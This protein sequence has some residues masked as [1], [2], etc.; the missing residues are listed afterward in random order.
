MNTL[1]RNGGTMG[2]LSAVVF[3]VLFL[4]FITSGLDFQTMNDPSKALPAFSQSPGRWVATGLV[5][6]VGSAVEI[7]FTA[8]LFIKLRER[9]PTRA[10]TVLLLAVVGSTGFALSSLLQWLGGLQ[11][12]ARL[13][14][15]QVAAS[16][17]YV[18]LASV[19][20]AFFGLGNAFVG[21]ALIIGGWAITTTKALSTG[22]GW[23]AYVT[24]I[25]TALLLFVPSSAFLNFASFALVIIW[26][27]WAGVELRR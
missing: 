26:L 14:T 15:D 27:A 13:P 22:V 21:A 8:G 24:G 17:A 25:V 16:H 6:V 7:V 12:A 1:Q 20:Q 23:L 11:L 19:N 4:L 18:A 9:A 10:A 2:V 5:G 3:A